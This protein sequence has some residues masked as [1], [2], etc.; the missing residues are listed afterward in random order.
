MLTAIFLSLVSSPVVVKPP[1]SSFIVTTPV[2]LPGVVAP[3]PPNPFR[4][5]P[6]VT[7]TIGVQFHQDGRLLWGGDMMRSSDGT[8]SFSQQLRESRAC[9]DADPRTSRYDANSARMSSLSVT[10]SPYYPATE[11]AIR[12]AIERTRPVGQPDEM[13]GGRD[14]SSTVRFEGRAIL[15]RGKAVT[16]EGEA[17]LSV[18]LTRR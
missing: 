4:G 16:L 6:R 1:D 3:P 15:P 2:T 14:G 13:C 18:T 10:L 7:E 5:A 12:V 17:G 11:G 9:P 8:A